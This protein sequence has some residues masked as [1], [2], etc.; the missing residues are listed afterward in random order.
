[1]AEILLFSIDEDVTLGTVQGEVPK[2]GDKYTYQGVN[3]LLNQVLYD[4]SKPEVS[5]KVFLRKRFTTT[6]Q[7]IL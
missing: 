4:P 1:M 2:E 6:K 3:Y 5:A 7:F